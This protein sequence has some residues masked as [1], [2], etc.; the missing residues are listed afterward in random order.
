[1]WM[2]TPSF[3]L[4]VKELLC[5]CLNVRLTLVRQLNSLNP[6]EKNTQD[7]T[8]FD[9]RNPPHF[10]KLKTRINFT[11]RIEQLKNF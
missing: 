2:H 4:A 8:V 6:I 10:G 7:W 9:V 5:S 1:M 3:S 11:V